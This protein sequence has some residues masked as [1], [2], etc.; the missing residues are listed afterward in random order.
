[1]TDMEL[2]EEYGVSPPLREVCD[3]EEEY[4]LAYVFGQAG[5]SIYT[6]IKC[7]GWAKFWN[8]LR[9]MKHHEERLNIRQRELIDEW[10]GKNPKR[11]ALEYDEKEPEMRSSF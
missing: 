2:M 3:S 4:V 6:Y 9:E 11:M 5:A 7:L 8:Q 1:M 10:T